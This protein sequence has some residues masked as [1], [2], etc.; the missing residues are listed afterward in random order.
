MSWDHDEIDEVRESALVDDR[1]RRIEQKRH[2]VEV[3]RRNV[4]AV[5]SMGGKIVRHVTTP[6]VGVLERVGQV[7]PWAALGVAA[8][9]AGF[10]VYLGLRRKAKPQV[11]VVREER[12]GKRGAG[13]A[14]T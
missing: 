14:T 5:T 2:R 7:L 8:G 10:L 11:I 3:A 4:Q 1:D 12:G 9:G 13:D 6:A